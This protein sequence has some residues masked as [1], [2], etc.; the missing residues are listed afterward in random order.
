MYVHKTI[1]DQ[2]GKTQK[3]LAKDI[4]GL[5]SYDPAKPDQPAYCYE[6]KG[7]DPIGIKFDNTN[8]EFWCQSDFQIAR[9]HID[10]LCFL[11]PSRSTVRS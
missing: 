2:T 3:E 4:Y 5:W 6:T 8:K 1:I 7:L 10:I 9:C 11:Y